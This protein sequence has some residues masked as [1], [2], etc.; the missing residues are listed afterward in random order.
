[1]KQTNE[2]S[3]CITMTSEEVP[4]SICHGCS[5]ISSEDL[6]G[7]GSSGQAG[8]LVMTTCVVDIVDVFCKNGLGSG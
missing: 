1:M 4:G 6:V 3:G 5:G 7:C 2:N 8:M